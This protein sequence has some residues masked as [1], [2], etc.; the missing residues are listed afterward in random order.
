MRMDSIGSLGDLLALVMQLERRLGEGDGI[1][2]YHLSLIYDP[3]NTFLNAQLKAKLPV[4]R[5]QATGFGI[6]AFPLLCEAAQQGDLE[7]MSIVATYFQ[8]GQPPVSLDYEK[9]SYWRDKIEK[10]R[11]C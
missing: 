5:E 6:R 9:Y 1:A 8:S 10:A 4:S 11:E 3:E 2:G 7:A